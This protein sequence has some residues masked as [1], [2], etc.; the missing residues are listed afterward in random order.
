M[1]LKA[2][3]NF[4]LN[5]ILNFVSQRSFTMESSYYNF[6]L[7]R[8]LHNKWFKKTSLWTVCVSTKLLSTITILKTYEIYEFTKGTTIPKQIRPCLAPISK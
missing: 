1:G 5:F 3:L 8:N 6:V 2:L 4:H 7:R